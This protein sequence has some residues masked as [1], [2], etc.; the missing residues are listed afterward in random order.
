MSNR[1][2]KRTYKDSLFRLV[3]REKR[4][5]LSLYN[6]INGTNYD[7]PKDLTIT[8]IDDVLYLS[9]KND[10]SFLIKEYMNLYEGQSTWNP[11]MPLRGIFYI[12]QLYQAYIKVNHLDIYSTK[13]LPIPTP[14]Y[15]VFYNGG[16]EEPDRQE[17]RLSDAFIKKDLDPCLECVALVLNINY[18]RNKALMQACRKLHDYSYFIFK[19][20]EYLSFPMTLEEAVDEA[21]RHCI[22]EDVLR[23]LLEKHQAEVR[24]VILTEYDEELHSRT[25]FEEGRE[26]GITEGR[27]MGI[28]QSI[29]GFLEEVGPVPDSLQNRILLEKDLSLLSRW[30]QIAA[31]SKNIAEFE[32][33]IRLTDT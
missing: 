2:I 9:L 24:H 27:R 8:T 30:N 7:N 11:N 31:R 26:F 22:K 10:I 12:S 1:I 25:L 6:A 13:L 32:Q 17:L 33:K 28:A 15:I 23:K 18:G 3:F 14:R 29:L 21:V 5:L 4:E 16:R 20:R 19:I